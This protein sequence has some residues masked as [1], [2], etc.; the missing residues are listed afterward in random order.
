MMPGIDGVDAFFACLFLQFTHQSFSNAIHTADGGYDPYLI[1]HTH[2]TVLTDIALERAVLLLDAKFFVYGVIGVFK[3]TGEIRLQIVLI[4]PVACLQVGFGMTDGIAILD[5]VS[6]LGGILDQD[7]VPCWR[8][9]VDGNLQSVNLND[10]TLL[11]RLQTDYHTV[12][13]INF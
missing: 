1:T 9:L 12:G 7:L 13:R 4:H 2:I 11:F 8:V 6:T 3:G 5:D 10:V